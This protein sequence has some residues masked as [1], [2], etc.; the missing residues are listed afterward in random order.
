[1]NFFPYGLESSYHH[2]LTN[3]AGTRCLSIGDCVYEIRQGNSLNIVEFGG[4]RGYA[5]KLA[6]P[7]KGK[8][9]TN[10]YPEVS[11]C[12]DPDDT[13]VYLAPSVPRSTK[14]KVMAYIAMKGVTT[15][16][17]QVSVDNS[18]EKLIIPSLVYCCME[19][20]EADTANLLGRGLIAFNP[21]ESTSALVRESGAGFIQKLLLPKQ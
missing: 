9:K 6:V 19:T 16:D 1:M 17:Y 3:P 11:F 18:F 13:T 15:F 4:L 12:P 10:H 20:Q 14:P 21:E 5:L 7:I 8:Y 2:E